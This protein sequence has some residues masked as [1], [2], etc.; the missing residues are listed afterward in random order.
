MWQRPVAEEH[1]KTPCLR[2]GSVS[3]VC[4]VVFQSLN[5]VKPYPKGLAYG[6]LLYTEVASSFPSRH[7]NVLEQNNYSYHNRD[8][9]R[10]LNTKSLYENTG[11]HFSGLRAADC[12]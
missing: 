10:T 2:L 5:A 6:F 7:E 11:R 12:S 4:M 1:A 9:V 3:R 8:N